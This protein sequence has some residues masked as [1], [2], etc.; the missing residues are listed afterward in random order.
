MQVY[1]GFDGFIGGFTGSQLVLHYADR[2][3]PDYI[4]Y[5]TTLNWQDQLGGLSC[6]YLLHVWFSKLVIKPTDCIL[7]LSF[8]HY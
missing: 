1:S 4:L 6:L 3:V 5:V 2:Y 8:I 7:I